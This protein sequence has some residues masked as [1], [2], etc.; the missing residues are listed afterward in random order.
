MS[1]VFLSVRSKHIRFWVC[2]A[3]D[4]SSTHFAGE[5]VFAV[6]KP[7]LGNGL[8]PSFNSS[9]LWHGGS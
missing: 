4:I 3:L 7:Y 6:R 8:I 9:F 2:H 1:V 5:Y